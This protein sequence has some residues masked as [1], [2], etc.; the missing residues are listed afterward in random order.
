MVAVAIDGPFHG[1]RVGSPL[2]PDEYQRAISEVG[3]KAVADSMV[4]DWIAAVDLVGALDGVDATRV[5]YVGLSMGTRFGLPLCAALGSTLRCVVFGKFGLDAAP[6]FYDGMDMS[7][8]LLQDA[9]RITAPCLFHIQCDDELFPR[10]G[11]LALF[12]AL[13]SPRKRVIAYSGKHA[14][15]D[16]GALALWREFVVGHLA[17]G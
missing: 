8:R 12:T 5:G 9:G 15:T 2:T 6:G 17:A 4:S 11:Q 3:I 14:E 1:D 13:A 16:D 10:E 7:E